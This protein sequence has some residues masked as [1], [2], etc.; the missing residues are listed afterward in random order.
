M[1]TLDEKDLLIQHIIFLERKQT[2]EL[3]LLKLEFHS[4]VEQLNPLYFI[5]NTYKQLTAPTDIKS[6]LVNGAVTM[7]SHFLTQNSFLS[8][9]QKP[10]KNILGNVVMSLLDKLNHKKESQQ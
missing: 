4:T 1:K 3:S 9:F 10:L 5:K 6:G 7:T 2:E 8:R